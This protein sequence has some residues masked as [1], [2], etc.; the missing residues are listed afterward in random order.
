MQLSQKQKFFSEF[1]TAFWKFSLNFKYS[2]EKHDPYR[3]YNS[4]ITD[5]ENVV[6]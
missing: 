3:F 4:E 5:S 6:I 1:L 2:E